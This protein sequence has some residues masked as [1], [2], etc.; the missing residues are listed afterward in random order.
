MHNFKKI[1]L[2]I[3]GACLLFVFITGILNYALI[4]YSYVK[5]MMHQVTTENFDTVFLGTSHGI[6]GINPKV[7]DAKT[8]EKNINLC[9]GG[10]Y[11]LDAYYFLKQVCEKHIPKRVVYELDYGYW[12]T[13][14]GQKG[15]FN[16]IFYEMPFS[17]AK[18]EYFAAKTMKTDF[19]ATV[20]PW[21]YYRSQYQNIKGIIGTKNSDVYKN[22]GTAPFQGPHQAYEDG[23]IKIKEVPGEKAAA[24]LILWDEKNL[25]EEAV[26]YFE[27]MV[28]FCRRKGIEFTVITTPIPREALAQNQKV[29]QKADEYFKQYLK[30]QQVPYINYNN[31]DK[32]IKNFDYS[33][34]I[35][36]DYEGHMTENQA[37]ALSNQLV[38]D[39]F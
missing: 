7:L 35:F 21:F 39:I 38:E 12:C 6:S 4:P 11:P 26:K 10:E 19:R 25:Q 37:E 27:K 20:F 8:G 13:P 34:N 2:P 3:A 15:D 22:L 31:P 18:L 24:G 5:I 29:F 9:M 28:K 23:F 16:R 32:M 33:L 14:K 30:Q 17:I 1:I 36:S